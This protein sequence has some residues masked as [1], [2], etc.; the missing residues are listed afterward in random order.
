MNRKGW[1]LTKKEEIEIKRVVVNLFKS[2]FRSGRELSP[3]C[4]D[5]AQG[6]GYLNSIKDL[7]L[8]E[9]HE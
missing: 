7:G 4:P 8:I 2:S 3:N 9:S 5:Y 1:F 6:F